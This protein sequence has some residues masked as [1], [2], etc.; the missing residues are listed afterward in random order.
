[1][2]SLGECAS[3]LDLI[4]L[5]TGGPLT[6]AN[7]MRQQLDIAAALTVGLIRRL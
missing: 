6:T 5:E 2:A 7:S 4:E 3:A 1:M